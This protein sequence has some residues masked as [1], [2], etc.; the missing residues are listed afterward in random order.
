[1]TYV[2]V[3]DIV[4]SIHYYTFGFI[5][6]INYESSSIITHFFS[7]FSLKAEKQGKEVSLQMIKDVGTMTIIKL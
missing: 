7:F 2:Y 4:Q 1:M 6:L 5:F 3:L